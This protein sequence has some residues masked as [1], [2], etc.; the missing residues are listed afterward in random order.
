MKMELKASRKDETLDFPLEIKKEDV[1]DDGFFKGYGSTFMGAP[2]SYG[3]VVAPGAFQKTIS[4]GGRN[5]T[6]IAC[7]WQ[8]MAA[9]PLGIY[10]VMQEDAKGLYLEGMVD[11]TA[12]PNGINVHR[13]MKMGSVRGLSIGFNTLQYDWDEKKKI[14][15]LKEVELWEVSL[16]TFPANVK[17]GVTG[18]KSILEARNERELEDALRE[19]GLSR[20]AAKYVVSLTKSGLREAGANQETW[21]PVLSELRKIN[22][23]LSMQQI[24]DAAT[25]NF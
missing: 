17:A 7:L 23:D 8:H 14:R 18:V 9:C 2:D 15:T 12:C 5:G 4:K 25:I 13:A 20:E 11:T 22:N 3:D 16:V 21:D 10:S 6:G 24:K 1:K 19:A